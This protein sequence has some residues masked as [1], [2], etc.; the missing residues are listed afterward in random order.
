MDERDNRV[1]DIGSRQK[2]LKDRDAPSLASERIRNLAFQATK[3]PTTLSKSEIEEL[4]LAV[5][6]HMRQ[7]SWSM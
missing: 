7:T 5:L 1:I 2:I 6:L 4:G 3:L